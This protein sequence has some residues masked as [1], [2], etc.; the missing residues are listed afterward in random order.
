MFLEINEYQ[1]RYSTE[2]TE[3]LSENKPQIDF[4]IER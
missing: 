2:D 1:L 3:R 4:L